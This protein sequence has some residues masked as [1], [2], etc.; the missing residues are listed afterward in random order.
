MILPK[1]SAG[2]SLERTLGQKY[3]GISVGISIPLWENKNRVKQA[4]AGVVAAQAQRAG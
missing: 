1:F 2:Y 4:K 3:Q